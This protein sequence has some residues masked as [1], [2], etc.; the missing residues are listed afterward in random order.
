MKDGVK[1]LKPRHY[2]V[3]QALKLEEGHQEIKIMYIKG[4]EA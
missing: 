2:K 3:A 4:L 1:G